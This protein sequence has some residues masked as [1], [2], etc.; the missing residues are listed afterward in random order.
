M[1]EREREWDC[2]CVY[3]YVCVWWASEKEYKGCPYTLLSR[4]DPEHTL[5]CASIS[6]KSL[7][8]SASANLGL[9][10]PNRTLQ[11]KYKPKL[12]QGPPVPSLFTPLPSCPVDPSHPQ[13]SVH[14]SVFVQPLNFSVATIPNQDVCSFNIGR[15]KPI[16][17]ELN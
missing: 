6:F 5:R 15:C 16:W 1:R 14:A 9:L 11:L 3:M 4:S 10:K 17:F 12:L 7:C 2:V 13:S 8:G